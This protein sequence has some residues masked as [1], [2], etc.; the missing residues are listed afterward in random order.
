MY[1]P[2]PIEPWFGQLELL[3]AGFRAIARQLFRLWGGPDDGAALIY[4][5]EIAARC[6]QCS[7]RALGESCVRQMNLDA[8]EHFRDDDGL[9]DVIDA[10]SL[11]AAHDMFGLG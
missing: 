11:E 3:A 4:C 6:I 2:E 5:K 8:R 7:P 10:S 9:G 1:L